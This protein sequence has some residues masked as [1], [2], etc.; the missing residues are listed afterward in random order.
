[1]RDFRVQ[2]TELTQ[3]THWMSKVPVTQK[4]GFHVAN[5]SKGTGF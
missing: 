1:M 5:D 3:D 2:K 4:L